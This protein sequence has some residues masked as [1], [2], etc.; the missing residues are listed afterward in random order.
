V[1]KSHGPIAELV[2]QQVASLP[3]TQR[4]QRDYVLEHPLGT[5]AKWYEGRGITVNDFEPVAGIQTFIA[6]TTVGDGCAEFSASLTVLVE[7]DVREEPK[8]LRRVVLSERV[9]TPQLAI[10]VESDGRLEILAGPDDLM[11]SA[12]IWS[13]GSNNAYQSR[14]L[15][16][17]L[18][19]DCAC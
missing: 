8:I 15:W 18:Y 6:S 2:K 19:W 10:D 16:S 4:V 13:Q 12:T 7:V 11:Q 5:K 1:R 17:L 3:E 14:D 9:L